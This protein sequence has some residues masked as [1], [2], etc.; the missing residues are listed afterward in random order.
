MGDKMHYATIIAAFFSMAYGLPFICVLQTP[1][2]FI[3][4]LHLTL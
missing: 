1:K 4:R 3:D 2:Y